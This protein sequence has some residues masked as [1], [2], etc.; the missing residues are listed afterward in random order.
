MSGASLF[1]RLGGE[2]GLRRLIDMLY[3][4][5]LADDYL[6]EY[7]MG[8]DID[9]VKALQL[10]FLRKTFGDDG[11]V[12]TGRPLHAAHQGQMITEQAFDQFIDTFAQVAG[13]LGVDAGARDEAIAAL[14]SMRA[15]VLLEFR[16]NPAY[17]Y[18]AKP[19]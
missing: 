3:Q 2:V 17:D 8:V 14:R 9:R 18:K 15:S 10:A 1:T 6:G 13:D 4:R 19:F 7:F 5:L 16:P 11:A 12:Y